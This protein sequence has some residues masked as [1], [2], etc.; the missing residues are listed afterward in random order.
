MK[1]IERSARTVEDALAEALDELQVSR[2]DV[3][4]EVL[5]EGAKAFWD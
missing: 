2:E 5:D 3:E 1:T 4:V